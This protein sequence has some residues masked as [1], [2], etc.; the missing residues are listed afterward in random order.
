MQGLI[1]RK[2]GMTRI[3]NDSGRVVAVTVIQAGNN[4]VHQVKKAEKDGYNAVQLGFDQ[5]AEQKVTKPLLGHFK[6]H[7]SSPTRVVREFALESAQEELKPG[8]QVGVEIL[9]D[10]KYVDVEG[11]SKGRGHAGT[12][13]KYNFQRGRETHGNTNVRERGSN[14]AGTYP[15]RIFPGLRMSGHYGACAVTTKRLEVVGID[16]EAGLVYIKGSVPGRNKGIVYLY[17]NK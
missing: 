13:K 10:S 4:V 7:N 17:K 6:K 11:V 16:K 3:F 1:G 8:Q 5:V 9:E 14:G 2:I 12:I 15:A